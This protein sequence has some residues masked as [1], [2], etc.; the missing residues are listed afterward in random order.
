MKAINKAINV[1]KTIE[2]FL[3]TY[4]EYV[5]QLIEKYKQTHKVGEK[6]LGEIEESN[7]LLQKIIKDPKKYLYHD[8]VIMSVVFDDNGN[9]GLRQAS[10][11]N[12]ESVYD[13]LR[14]IMSV[15]FA[16]HDDDVLFSL[17]NYIS[18]HVKKSGNKGGVWYAD[19]AESDCW[20]KH[21]LILNKKLLLLSASN[22][23]QKI[24]VK[25]ST[26]SSLA[27]RRP[28]RDKRR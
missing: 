7:N 8:D 4:G 25:V 10:T 19:N 2:N 3:I 5:G 18:R 17:S 20:A 21:I 1:D 22:L 13:K 12:N 28:S 14:G 11:V 24:A 23:I 6:Q 15:W 26:T 16:Y 9:P 27:V